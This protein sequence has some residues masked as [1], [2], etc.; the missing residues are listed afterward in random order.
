MS[1]DLILERL[2]QICP[3][4]QVKSNV[5]L[6]QISRWRIG[7]IAKY[8]VIPS[9]VSYLSNLL[10]FVNLNGLPYIVIGDTT[11]ILFTDNTINAICIKIG[12]NLSKISFSHDNVYCEAG[13]WVPYFA[14]KI[15]KNKL[16]G[17]EHTCG[18]PGS[19]GGLICMNGG[20]QRKGIG[21]NIVSVKAL[22]KAGQTL[23]FTQE[24]C[25]FS[26]RSSYF[27]SSDLIITSAKFSFELSDSCKIIRNR[28]L[29]ILSSRRKKFPSKLPNCGSVFKSD[30][31]MYHKFGAPGSILESIGLKNFT[32]GSAMISSIHANFF[33]N[34]SN[35]KA[36]DMV[37]LIQY[38]HNRAFEVY[39]C[40]LIPEVICITQEGKE[41]SPLEILEPDLF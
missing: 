3:N 29:E 17:A 14:R 31:A 20:S 32:L 25:L 23:E 13:L 11:N 16:S 22:N 38:A 34:H 18:I 30:P 41:M 1:M 19:V 27:Q 4:G 2:R 10:E 12:A 35:A 6:N 39:G 37:K 9:S 15:M 5:S 36:S 21:E 26:Y 33:I 8:L 7:G 40:R 28:M 24:E